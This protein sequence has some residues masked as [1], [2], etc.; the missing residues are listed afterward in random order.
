MLPQSPDKWLRMGKGSYGDNS[1]EMEGAVQGEKAIVVTDG[2][3]YLPYGD[4]AE[5][6]APQVPR[7]RRGPGGPRAP[8]RGDRGMPP[9]EIT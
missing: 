4:T 8:Q 3:G 9:P 5:M 1:L 7:F 2:I 6:N